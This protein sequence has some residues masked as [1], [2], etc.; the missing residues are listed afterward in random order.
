MGRDGG[1]KW[2]EMRKLGGLAVGGGECYGD[3]GGNEF[4][5]KRGGLGCEGY[6]M[7]DSR[8]MWDKGREK[9]GEEETLCEIKMLKNVFGR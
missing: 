5:I 6:R 9:V 7:R 2:L 1:G 3:G 8:E 4:V